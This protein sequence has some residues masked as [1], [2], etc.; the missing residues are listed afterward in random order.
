VAE[1]KTSRDLAAEK[2]R[3]FWKQPLFY[4]EIIE[5]NYEN[6]DRFVKSVSEL[7]AALSLC[8]SDPL[9][10]E[11]KASEEVIKETLKFYNLVVK[12]GRFIETLKSNPEGVAKA[13][14]VELSDEAVDLLRV[15]VK[16]RGGAS[17]VN[18]VT[19]VTITVAEI[20]LGVVEGEVVV[21]HSKRVEL[22]V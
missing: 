12:D 20:V 6:R 8:L 13:L 18:E 3:V 5:A 19:I 10:D 7:E 14:C 15:G 11:I 4:R 9:A 21:D 2:A 17:A 16:L 1:E 22:K